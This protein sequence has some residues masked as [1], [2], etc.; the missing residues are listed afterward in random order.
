MLY[1]VVARALKN[2]AINTG[3]SFA[4]LYQGGF[5]L[6]VAKVLLLYDVQNI[7]LHVWLPGQSYCVWLVSKVLVQYTVVK[8]LE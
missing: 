7:F 4:T 2:K 1:H 5:F 8:D 3:S 6:V